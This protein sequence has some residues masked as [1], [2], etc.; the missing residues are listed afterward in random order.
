MKQSSSLQLPPTAKEW[1]AFVTHIWAELPTQPGDV[2]L[3]AFADTARWAVRAVQR[4]RLGRLQA[5]ELLAP[6]TKL[7]VHPLP[8]EVVEL[9]DT[10]GDMF[11]D[12]YASASGQTERWRYI[13]QLVAD[14]QSL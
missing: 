7:D 2:Q 6:A 13:E 1:S 10:A 4:D 5:A 8:W 3:K 9:A 12:V 14:L 11:S